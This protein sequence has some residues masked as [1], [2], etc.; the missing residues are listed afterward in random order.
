MYRDYIT[1][2]STRKTIDTFL[3]SGKELFCIND[4]FSFNYNDV[5]YSINFIIKQYIPNEKIFKSN[6]TISDFKKIY[7]FPCTLYLNEID[8]FLN[9]DKK[10]F[11]LEKIPN[12][13]L[14]VFDFLLTFK[15]FFIDNIPSNSDNYDSMIT[16]QIPITIKIQSSVNILYGY[17]SYYGDTST[18]LIIGYIFNEI[19]GNDILYIR[20][21]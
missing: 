3:N 1:I 5:F 10:N 16:F 11:K 19:C 9:H 15:D 4:R 7:K 18:F 20:R 2:R 6:I 14:P 17:G 13:S 21:E 12:I 8:E